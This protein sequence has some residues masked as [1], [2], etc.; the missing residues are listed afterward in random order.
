MP[1]Q[2]AP[3]APAIGGGPADSFTITRFGTVCPATKLRFDTNGSETSGGYTVRNP[4]AAG[5]VAVTFSTTDAMP[6]TGRPTV[7]GRRVS[8]EKPAPILPG[9]GKGLEDRVSMRRTGVTGTKRPASV[10][11]VLS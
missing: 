3:V 2:P 9:G 10:A 1:S 7:P 5:S 8:S 6:V 11:L 4:S